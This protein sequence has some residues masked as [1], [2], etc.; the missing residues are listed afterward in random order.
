[1]SVVGESLGWRIPIFLTT[2]ISIFALLMFLW[3][4]KEPSQQVHVTKGYTAVSL[5]GLGAPIWLVGLAWM[6]FNAAFISFL[7]FS[8]KFFVDKGYEKGF[9]SFMSSIVMMG[10]LLISSLIGYVLHKFGKEELFIGTGGVALAI[11][12]T[13]FPSTS[14]YFVM[15][16]L[17]AIVSALTP[18]PIFSLPSKMVKPENLGLGFGILSMCSNV[19]VLVGP[20]LAGLAKDLTNAYVFSFYLMAFFAALETLVIVLFHFLKTK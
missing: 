8:P 10:P 15:L 20:Y 7:T 4:F 3:W 19:G 9:A 2:L 5:S 17:I 11:L 14:F 16:V 1:L 18:P 12:L 6:W 13:F